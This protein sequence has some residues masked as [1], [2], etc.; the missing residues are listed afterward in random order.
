MKRIIV[1][2][3]IFFLFCWLPVVQAGSVKLAN[4]QP[5]S[6]IIE[7]SPSLSSEQVVEIQLLGLKISKGDANTTEMQQVW[8]F[9]HPSNKAVT[10]PLARFATLFDSPAYR[11]LLGHQDASIIR[12]AETESRVQMQVNVTGTDGQSYV[13][14]WVVG[15]AIEGSDA[16]SW[17]TLSVSIPRGGGTQS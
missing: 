2:C 15:K 14:L 16:G 17:M 4:N 13:Y 6:E 11:P 3:G 10:G 8:R 7:P 1:S 12:L 5:S 9:A